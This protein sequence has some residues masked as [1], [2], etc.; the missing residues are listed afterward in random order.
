MYCLGIIAVATR[1]NAARPNHDILDE[2]LQ[3]LAFFLEEAR[4]YRRGCLQIL[5][6]KHDIITNRIYQNAIRRNAWRKS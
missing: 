2:D 6:T 1:I 4:I 5:P 3:Y